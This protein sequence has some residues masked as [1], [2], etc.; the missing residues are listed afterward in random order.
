M[1]LPPLVLMMMLVTDDVGGG[2]GDGGVA[3]AVLMPDG[4]RAV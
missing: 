3:M 1:L 4:S 2:C